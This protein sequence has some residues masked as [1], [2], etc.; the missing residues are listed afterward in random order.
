MYNRI[1][2]V[3]IKNYILRKD[4]EQTFNSLSDILV[5]GLFLNLDFVCVHTGIAT[6]L[7]DARRAILSKEIRV[8]EHNSEYLLL[9]RGKKRYARLLY[10]SQL[11]NNVETCV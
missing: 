5:D 11:H 2:T 4:I 1:I 3:G 9:A 10:Q 8:L 7:S 6:S